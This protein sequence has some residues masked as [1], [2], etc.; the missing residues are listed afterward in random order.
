MANHG[1][2]ELQHLPAQ[3]HSPLIIRQFQVA[4][5]LDQSGTNANH[6]LPREHTEV[7]SP[8]QQL[9]PVDGGVAAWRFLFGAFMIEALQWGGSIVKILWRLSFAESDTRLCIELWSIS[10]LLF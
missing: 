10:E 6:T 4:K 2:A 5:N 7:E 9:C 1:I 8:E 3:G